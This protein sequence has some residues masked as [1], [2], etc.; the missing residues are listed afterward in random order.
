M[1]INPLFASEERERI[2]SYLLEHPSERINMNQLARKLRLSPGQ[3]HKYMTILRKEKLVTKDL[4]KPT[5]LTNVLRMMNNLKRIERAGI[6]D[7]LKE[8]FPK[9]TGIG[10]YGSWASGANV[11]N[12]DLDLWLKM[13]KEPKDLEIA[14]IRKQIENI[15]GAPADIVIATSERLEH[16]HEKSDSFYFSLFNGITLWGEVL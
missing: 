4:L 7:L 9:S 3:I 8:N 12:S 11:E 16:F 10:M 6:V 5:P 1:N 15:L 2:L 14:R 13:R